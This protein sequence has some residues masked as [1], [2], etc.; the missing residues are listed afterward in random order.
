[1]L[2]AG[3]D[4]LGRITAFNLTLFF[5]SI[6]GIAASYAPTF[7]S[8]CIAMFFLGSAVGVSITGL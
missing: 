7:P 3:S 8:L 4:L 5:T 1:V 6:F 2:L